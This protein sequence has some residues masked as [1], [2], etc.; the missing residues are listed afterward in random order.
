MRRVS[1][2]R[3][4][5]LATFVA[6]VLGKL[7]PAVRKLGPAVRRPFAPLWRDLGAVVALAL[8]GLLVALLPV[9][10]WVNAVA[11]LPLVLI[12]PGYA[13]AAAL[14]LPGTINRD[15]RVVLVVAFSVGASALG[16]V[17]VQVV[18]RLDRPVWAALLFSITALASAVAL[19]RRDGLPADHHLVS[20]RPPRVGALSATAILAAAAIAGWGIAIAT[21]G[22]HR[23][24]ENSHLSSL[25]VVPQQGGAAT[26]ADAPVSIGVSNQE[27]RD[28]SYLLRV[29]KDGVTLRDWR[30]H[31]VPDQQWQAGLAA[32]TVSGQG[33]LLV[34]LYRGGELY[35]HASLWIGATS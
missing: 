12:L 32:P 25:W 10:G 17:L 14:L 30:I 35:R 27:G 23:Q 4:G 19:I 15:Y 7:G 20:F 18:F 24:L 6:L 29:K 5:D 31:L 3:W 8:L 16:G 2:L 21:G 11:L 26:S 13:L 1:A 9:A 33:P 34:E 28:A 22:A